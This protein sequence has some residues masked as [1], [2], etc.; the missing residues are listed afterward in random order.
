MFPYAN[1]LTRFETDR[2][3]E[4][5]Q[6]ARILNIRHCISRIIQLYDVK[7]QDN[8]K[9]T[10]GLTRRGNSGCHGETMHL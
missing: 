7:V 1:E 9:Y 4:R 2:S 5:L 8:E 6:T 3:Q 10:F